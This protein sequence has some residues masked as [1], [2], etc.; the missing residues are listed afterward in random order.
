MLLS[1]HF[2]F[3]MLYFRLGHTSL[4]LVIN[5]WPFKSATAAGRSQSPLVCVY[6]FTKQIWEKWGP[7]H[8]YAAG[9]SGAA[10]DV[11]GV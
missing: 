1:L 6:M 3:L 11:G 5:T 4:P 10:S 9:G 8:L 2:L 7:H